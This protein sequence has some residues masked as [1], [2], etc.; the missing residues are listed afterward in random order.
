MTDRDTEFLV[1][2]SQVCN[3]VYGSSFVAVPVTSSSLT[4]LQ[5]LGKKKHIGHKSHLSCSFPEMTKMCLP[6]SGNM[7]LS[8]AKCYRNG[9]FISHTTC[10]KSAVLTEILS[11]KLDSKHIPAGIQGKKFSYAIEAIMLYFNCVFVRMCLYFTF[12]AHAHRPMPKNA[13]PSNCKTKSRE[14][15]SPSD[16]KK[17]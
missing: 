9:A 1:A 4:L 17:T 14:E 16:G 11:C 15:A 5:L 6:L 3:F 8:A 10:L 13:A 12:S 2:V 7:F